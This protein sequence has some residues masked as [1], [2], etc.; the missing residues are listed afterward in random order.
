MAF[1]RYFLKQCSA[2]RQKQSSSDITHS[3]N[4]CVLHITKRAKAAVF[5]N[6]GCWERRSAWVFSLNSY[7]SKNILK[8]LA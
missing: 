6:G 4:A 2:L 1:P 7:Y 5:Q 8:I 3:Q